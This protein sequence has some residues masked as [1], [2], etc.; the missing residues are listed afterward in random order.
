MFADAR[1]MSFGFEQAR[2]VSTTFSAAL[3]LASTVAAAEPE[4]AAHAEPAEHH[5]R[6]VVGAN[7]MA[8]GAISPEHF[9]SA[10][11][12]G[13]F[14]EVV[15]VPDWLELELSA[16]YLRTMTAV[17]EVPVDVLIKKPFHPLRWLNPYVGVGP[18]VVAELGPEEPEVLAGLVAVAGSYFW[19]TSDFGLSAELDYNVV[20][21]DELVQE[22]AGLSGMVVGF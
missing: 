16:H 8:L 1:V 7:A 18:T 11:G 2:L 5:H 10:L 20:K 12:A 13:A 19:L 4:L 21:G 14:F 15:A 9:V 6:F 22:I 3:L 17:D